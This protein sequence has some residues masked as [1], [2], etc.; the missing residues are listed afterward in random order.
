M[1]LS[2]DYRAIPIFP[3]VSHFTFEREDE[4]KALSTF[5]AGLLGIFM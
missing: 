2:T 3:S 4:T 5:F 1:V